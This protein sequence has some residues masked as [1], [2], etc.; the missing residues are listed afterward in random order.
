MEDKM[1]ETETQYEL[2][3]AE[4]EDLVA[5]DPEQGTAAADRLNFLVA[6]AEKYELSLK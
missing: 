5:V 1:I 6:L 3:M 4:I 2:V